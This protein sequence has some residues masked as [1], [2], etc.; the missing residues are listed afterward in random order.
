MAMVGHHEI[1]RSFLGCEQGLHGA[2][3][4]A[5]E[6]SASIAC[7]G[8]ITHHVENPVYPDTGSH[9]A[10]DAQSPSL[11]Q[12][13]G[14]PL[15]TAQQR[16]WMPRTECDPWRATGQNTCHQIRSLEHPTEGGIRIDVSLRGKK[17]IRVTVAATRSHDGQH[18]ILVEHASG[19]G[20]MDLTYTEG[21][22]GNAIQQMVDGLQVRLTGVRDGAGQPLPEQFDLPDFHGHRKPPRSRERH[23]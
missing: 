13:V 6:H 5:M 21:I 23:E 2:R 17:C 19:H 14:K 22:E 10:R 7:D 8:H 4:V 11:P 15:I 16:A 18:A 12:L 9:G 3:A 1:D 20:I